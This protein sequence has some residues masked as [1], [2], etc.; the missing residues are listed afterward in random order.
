MTAMISPEL[1]SQSTAQ[2]DD[3]MVWILA[4]SELAAFA[5]MMMGFVIASWF[6]PELFA[7]GKARLHH[8]IALANTVVLLVSGWCAAL[9][10]RSV[11][12]RQQ[13][14][15]LF[16]SAASGI[17]FVALKLYEYQVEGAS[18]LAEDSF[19]QLY[20]LITGFHLVHVL[21]GSLVLAL[22]ARFPSPQ[23]IH[24]VTTLWHVIDIVWLV[25][26]PVVYL[27]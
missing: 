2:S 12:L 19:W 1:R 7:A 16:A 22:M 18:L 5:A 25:M 21:F 27:L 8:E 17:L 20:V 4:W 9:A 6:Q 24:L 14:Q 15:A 3:L 13:R 10:A 11:N 23:N 26:F